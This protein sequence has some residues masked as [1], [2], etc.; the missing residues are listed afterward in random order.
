[1]LFFIYWPVVLNMPV[2]RQAFKDRRK[3]NLHLSLIKPLQPKLPMKKILLLTAAVAITGSVFSQ[4]RLEISGKG[5]Y[6]S[7]WMFNEN[8]SN[9][10][11]VQD[12]D[13]GWAPN[14]GVGTAFYFSK[15]IGIEVNGLLG[16]FSGRFQGK[17]DSLGNY[18]SRVNLSTFDIPL[19]FKLRTKSGGAYLELGPQY[20]LIS[21]ALYSLKSDSMNISNMD[22]SDQ[23]S[24]TNLALVFGLGVNIE[25]SSKLDLNTG[26]RFEYGISDLKGVDAVGQS[27]ENFFEYPEYKRTFTAAGGVLLGL[28]YKIGTVGEASSSTP[29]P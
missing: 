10:G 9:L 20:T 13:L 11:D 2:V 22:V 29:A 3:N 18:T 6:R 4:S 17:S 21:K 24:K 1:M 15:S 16:S 8:L 27:F 23:Y 7:T 12:Y 5:T 26:F 25:L 14:Y 28:T 19:L